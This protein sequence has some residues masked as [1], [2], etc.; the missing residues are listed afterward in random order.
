MKKSINENAR[1]PDPYEDII[2]DEKLDSY[3]SLIQ[4]DFSIKQKKDQLS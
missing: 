4:I 3:E 2:R 1:N